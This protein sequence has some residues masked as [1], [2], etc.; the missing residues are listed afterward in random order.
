MLFF[1]VYTVKS[2]FTAMVLLEKGVMLT[3]QDGSSNTFDPGTFVQE[4]TSMPS[5]V[6]DNPVLSSEVQEILRCPVCGRRLALAADEAVCSCGAIFPTINGVPILIHPERSIFDAEV[7]LKEEATFFKP[8]SRWRR[9]IS[10]CL[11]SLSKNVAAKR[12]FRRLRDILIEECV[13]ANVQPKV[14]VVGGSVLGDGM[15][16]LAEDPRIQLVETDVSLGPRAAIICDGHD[17][18]F[19]DGSFD[20]VIVQA[21]LE[22]VTDPIRCVEEI[23][24]VLRPGGLVY[25]DTPFMQQIHGREYDFSRFT[26]LG[27]RRLFRDFSEIESGISCGPGTALAWS[28]QYFG[29]S[30]FRGRRAR[31]AVNGLA[32]LGFFW[33][34]YFDPFLAKRESAFDAASAFYFLGRKELTTISDEHLVASYQG[35]F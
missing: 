22:H 35:G 16:S 21:V 28:L 20:A 5:V 8:I 26:R 1:S 19:A 32:R 23:K 14:L 9:W 18:P 17:L 12:V 6:G 27:H 4:S 33:L 31:A 7:F 25:S 11:P 10:G 29:L 3:T 24:R 2:S 15:E 13:S 30:F 34:K